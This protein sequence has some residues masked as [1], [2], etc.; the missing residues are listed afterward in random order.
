MLTALTAM[1]GR[2]Q[3]ILISA[4]KRRATVANH[5]DALATANLSRHLARVHG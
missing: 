2:H 5:G 4:I 1:R 3:P